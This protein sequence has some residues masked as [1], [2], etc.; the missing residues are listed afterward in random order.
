MKIRIIILTFLTFICT[1]I[2]AQTPDYLQMREGNRA[3]KKQDYSHAEKCYLKAL[4]TNP[5]NARAHFNL[6]DCYL[7]QKKPEDALKY[8]AEAAEKEQNKN[9][10]AMAFNNMGYIHH[11]NKNY[12][13]A[14]ESYKQS[15]RLNPRDNDVRYNLALAQK[16][17]KQ[18]DEQQ[19]QQQ[20]QQQQ[21][22]KQQDEQKQQQEQKNQQEQQNQQNRQQEQQK[23]NY[24]QLL[25]YSRQAEDQTRKKIEKCM[26]P[27]KKSLG[28]NW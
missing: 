23:Q 13:K 19:Q 25:N 8:F 21:Q 1:S 11:V 20:P 22:E 10:K 15:L 28:K 12:D 14:I 4:E 18:Q 17:K 26:Q 27:R 5:E 6:A 16:Q 7:A 24:D 3:F 9:V 2:S